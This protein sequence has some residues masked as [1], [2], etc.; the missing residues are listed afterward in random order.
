M[1]TIVYHCHGEWR[2]GDTYP[3]KRECI[4]ALEMET[5]SVIVTYRENGYYV[6]GH[7]HAIIKKC[8]LELNGFTED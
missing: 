7:G 3:L 6:T 8:D 1:W 5:G 4:E 2:I